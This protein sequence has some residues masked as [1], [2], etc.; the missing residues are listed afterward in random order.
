MTQGRQMI[1]QNHDTNWFLAQLKPNCATIAERNLIRQ[2]FTTFLP[3]EETTQQR[4]GK[5]ITAT[6]P[7]FP[8]YIFVALNVLRGP[9]RS[10]NS[11]YGVTRL[12]SF[13]AAPASVPQDFVAQLQRRCDASGKL[14]PPAA[15]E[16]GDLVTVT[17]GPF[18]NV[19][20]EILHVTPD[21]RVWLLMDI[22]GA[23]ARVVVEH[24]ML[25]WVE[26]V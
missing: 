19:I 21:Q 7:L 25:Q 2:G 5:F 16:P 20:A 10:V 8:G 26:Q 17:K 9:W 6:R 15:L 13:G 4:N 14:L 12:V 18:A 24:D 23:K 22:M 1:P 3:R 11:T